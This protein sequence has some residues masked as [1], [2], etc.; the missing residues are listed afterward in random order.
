MADMDPESAFLESQMDD[1]YDP[2]SNYS[3]GQAYDPAHVN[4]AAMGE[5]EEEDEDEEYDPSAAFAPYPA[6]NTQ[7][8]SGQSASMPP[9]SAA[10]S[11]PPATADQEMSDVKPQPAQPAKQPRT[12]GGFVVDSEDDEDEAPESKKPEASGLDGVSHSP[13]PALSQTH[14]P[15]NAYAPP[16]VPVVSAQVQDLG[17]SGVSSSTSVPVH[18]QAPVQSPAVTVQGNPVPDQ[19]QSG[20]SKLSN[21]AP[22]LPAA[23]QVSPVTASLPKAR[24]P[25][26]RVGI[27]ED[28][29]AEDPRGDIEAWL[30]LIEELRRRHKIDDA[31]GVYDR[32][33]KIFPTAVSLVCIFSNFY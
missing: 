15:S 30:G 32:F 3:S 11:P 24:L 21:A 28:R 17:P 31:R 22:A 25:Q 9:E 33:L 27:F 13:S 26:D 18:D 14:T 10:N 4:P 5:E 29:I 2:T 23:A 20:A 6:R 8:P 19:A 7:S 16:N 12:R 1:E